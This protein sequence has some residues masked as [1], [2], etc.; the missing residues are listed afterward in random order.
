MTLNV[1]DGPLNC[2]CCLQAQ[3][4]DQPKPPQRYLVQRGSGVRG[5][6]TQIE[7]MRRETSEKP[8]NPVIFGVTLGDKRSGIVV[9][10]ESLRLVRVSLGRG[11]MHMA[12]VTLVQLTT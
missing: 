12:R 5:S 1:C 4:T 9:T 11:S 2:R 8:S 10:R 3:Q 6:G 7:A